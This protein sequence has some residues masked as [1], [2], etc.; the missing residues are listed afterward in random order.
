MENMERGDDDEVIISK[1]TAIG[2]KDTSN[3]KMRMEEKWRAEMYQGQRECF[4]FIDS[5]GAAMTDSPDIEGDDFS[6]STLQPDTI[7]LTTEMYNYFLLQ[8]K[9]WTE[10]AQQQFAV[11]ADDPN[12]NKSCFLQ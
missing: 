6:S 8:K 5:I 11:K 10:K 2:V 7:R 9:L 1:A 12:F 4:A 3:V